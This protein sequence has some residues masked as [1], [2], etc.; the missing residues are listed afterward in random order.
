MP[1]PNL[2][3]KLVKPKENLP[4]EIMGKPA[5]ST[6]EAR[7][8]VALWVNGWTFTYQVWLLGGRIL[9]GGQ[10]IDFLVHTMPNSTP[11]YVYGDYWHGGPKKDADALDRALIFGIM[12]GSL[13][14]PEVLTGEQLVDL[15]TAI[16]AVFRM[17]GRGPNPAIPI[18]SADVGIGAT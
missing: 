4:T 14:Q 8:A 2:P 15:D 13:R 9:K 16:A 7:T 18:P 5:G 6:W 17:F 12:G 1:T 3:K 11:L 10:V